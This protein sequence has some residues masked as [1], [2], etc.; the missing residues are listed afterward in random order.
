MFKS[1]PLEAPERGRT[2]WPPVRCCSRCRA[3]SLDEDIGTNPPALPAALRG[4]D[5]VLGREESGEEDVKE[6]W[7]DEELVGCAEVEDDEGRDP[8]GA[9]LLN[10]MAVSRA[11][12]RP[13][14]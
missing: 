3:T 5:G 14:A 13:P 9:T 2:P 12:E 8:A 6:V 7:E 4:V 10:S 1:D 11:G